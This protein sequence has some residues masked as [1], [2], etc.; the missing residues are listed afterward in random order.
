[1]FHIYNGDEDV[2]GFVS[3]EDIPGF[4]G[5]PVIVWDSFA[6]RATKLEEGQRLAVRLKPGEA[7]MYSIVPVRHG[8]EPVGLVDKLV[9]AH[10]IEHCRREEE[11]MFV[12]LK[13]GGKFVFVTEWKPARVW[14][15]GRPANVLA[16]DGTLGAYEV[17][18]SGENGPVD[19]EIDWRR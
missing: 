12:R 13:E 10:A 11:R 19:I 3:A 5:Q 8:A 18:C 6:G 7:A 1:L 14:A 17:D 15:N 9:P 4:K 2:E 16:G